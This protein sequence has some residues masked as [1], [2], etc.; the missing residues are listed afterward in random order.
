MGRNDPITVAA[1][2]HDPE[3]VWQAG[4]ERVFAHADLTMTAENVERIRQ[5]FACLRCWELQES[6]F[7]KDERHLPGCEYAPDGIKERQRADFAR[8]FK[9]TKWI[10]PEKSLAEEQAEEHEARMKALERIHR[11]VAQI[12]VPRGFDAA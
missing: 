7:P 4:D 8:E 9:G 12:I 11:P 10:G 3:Y 1:V 6:A 2:E 5:G